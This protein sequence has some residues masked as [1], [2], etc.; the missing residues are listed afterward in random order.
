MSDNQGSRVIFEQERGPNEE[1]SI[2]VEGLGKQ[3]VFRI[4]YD[5]ELVQTVTKQAGDG[6]VDDIGGDPP[7]MGDGG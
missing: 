3:A 4:Y 1:V 2:D 5:N 6:G 7:P